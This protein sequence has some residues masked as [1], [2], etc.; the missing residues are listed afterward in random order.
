[1]VDPS[2]TVSLRRRAA[3]WRRVMNYRYVYLLMLPGILY[4]IIMK[5]VPLA[6]L[7]IAFQDYNPFAGMMQSPFVGL[8]HFQELFSSKY[9]ALMFRNT[10]VIS[11]MSLVF[12]FPLPIILSVMMSET[13]HTLFKRSV[14]S[15]VYLPHF[16][17]RVVVAS[18]TFFLL[19]VDSGI[20]NKILLLT[21]R[22]QTSFLSNPNYFWIIITCQTI[23][24]ESGWGTILFL[25]AIT[26]IDPQRYEAAV[27]D[28]AGRLQQ[29]WHVTIPG[30]LPTIVTMLI[31]RLG[32]VADISVE[33]IMLMSNPLVID[34]AEVF[35]TYAFTQGVQRGQTSIGVAVGLFK[36]L[37]N[38]AL[39]VSSNW[40]VKKMGSE[41]IF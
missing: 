6:G 16:L 37:I 28:G 17:S 10:M 36:S 34:V 14:Q 5:F 12:F 22:E 19:S 32:Q 38:L 33:Q 9:F 24:R 4:F 39:V 41:G 25:A 31:L 15:L 11:L 27:I 8:K 13:R 21:G 30:I 7:V 1:M 35:D 2:G 18:M 20:V 29:I 26:N 40:V 23:W 3:R